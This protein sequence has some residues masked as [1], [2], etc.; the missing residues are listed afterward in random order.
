[1]SQGQAVCLEG[2]VLTPKPGK[3]L[4]YETK[5]VT[6]KTNGQT[7]QVQGKKIESFFDIF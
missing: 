2:D 5:N 4:I 1:L 7:K 6:N 3:S